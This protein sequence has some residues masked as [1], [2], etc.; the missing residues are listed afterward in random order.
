MDRLLGDMAEVCA[1]SQ[2]A[3]CPQSTRKARACV[4]ASENEGAV[5]S[6]S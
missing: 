1:E 3:S 5:A 6:E 2:R 4:Q